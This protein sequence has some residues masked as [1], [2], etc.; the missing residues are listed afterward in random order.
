MRHHLLIGLA[1]APLFAATAAH[2]DL[3]FEDQGTAKLGT[4]PCNGSGCWTNYARVTDVDGDGDLDIV[5]VNC[6]GFFS[7][8]SPQPLTVYTNDGAGNFTNGSAVFGNY[9]AALRQVAFGDIDNDGDID[10]Y[11]PAAGQ[12]QPDALF[13]NENGTFVNQASAR[14]PA[15]LSSDA[16]ATRFGDFDNDGDLDIFVAN[17]YIND[18]AEP[19]AIYKNDGAGVFTLAVGAVP[20][21]A[22]G[23][24]P[25]DVDLADFDGDFDLDIL[26]NMHSGENSLWLNNGDGTFTD[27]SGGLAPNGGGLHYGPGVCD[28]DNDGDRD[29]LIDNI[30]GNYLEQLLINNGSGVFTDGTNKISGN[31]AG[32]DDNIVSCIDYDNDGAFDIVVG[33]L[34][35]ASERVFH[36]DGAGNFS[37][38]TQAFTATNDSTLW[39]EFGDLNGDGRLD[40]LTAQGEGEELERVFFGN[41]GVAQDTVPPTIGATDMTTVGAD[42]VIRFA[43]RDN[44]VT[45]E[46]PRLR[47]AFLY[48]DNM[49]VPARFMGGDLYRAVLPPGAAAFTAC[50]ED[51]AGNVTANCGGSTTTT[52]SSTGGPSTNATGTTG[53]D[54]GSSGSAMTTT[55]SNGAGGGGDDE[56]GSEGGCDCSTQ[57]TGGSKAAGAFGL[58]ALAL[59]L[60]RLSRRVRQ[61]STK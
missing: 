23:V 36:N 52:T 8:P 9:T 16:G 12:E 28:V 61:G 20:V 29:I 6:G 37:V 38:V 39:M 45:D 25:D 56:T 21:S 3:L 41:M 22:D 54:N 32:A 5:A 4:Q 10:V 14:L 2:A 35:S 47:R 17:G 11:A 59:G 1:L 42:T 53:V 49:E 44:A 18:N 46:G 34:S 30:G 7:N 13:V 60:S 57:N 19:G 33:S 50:A 15:G 26:I 40:A 27:A 51:I 31:S 58:L 43:V 24:N 48:V 55:G